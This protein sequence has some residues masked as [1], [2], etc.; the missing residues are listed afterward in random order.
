[1]PPI[2]GKTQLRLIRQAVEDGV[3]MPAFHGER[4]AALHAADRGIFRRG[5]IGHTYYPTPV[6]R[7]IVEWHQLTT[8][9]SSEDSP[10]DEEAFDTTTQPTMEAAP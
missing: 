10:E 5:D 4:I 8:T 6:A 7:E 2:V 9:T 1:M 3:I